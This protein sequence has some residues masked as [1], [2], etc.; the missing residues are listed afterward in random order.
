MR[1]IV[2]LLL[3]INVSAAYSQVGFRRNNRAAATPELSYSSP[4]ELEIAEIKVEGSEFLDANALISITGLKVGDVIKV[5]GD[6]IS[7]AI[8]KLWQQGIIGNVSIQIS[9]IEEGK[10]FLVI[11]LTERPRLTRFNFAGVNKSQESELNDKIKLIKGRVLTDAVLKNTEINVKKYFVDKGFLNTE[12]K[13]TQAKDTLISNG[14]QL[15]IKVNKNAKVKINK[16]VF[17]GN[18][19]VKDATLKRKMKNTHEHAR[20]NIIEDMLKHVVYSSP[21]QWLYSLSHRDT[22]PFKAAK[23]YINDHVKLNVFNTS[24]LIKAD[25]EEDK[26]SLITY[27]NA[28][29]FRDA[30]IVSDTFYRHDNRTIDIKLTINEGRKYYFRDIIWSGNYVYTDAVLDRILDVKKGDVYDMEMINK[31]LNYNPQGADISSL[32]MD[33]GYLFFTINPVEVRVEGDSI[34]VEMRIFEGKQA[35]INKL[36]VKGN[37]RTSDHVILRE[38][39][40]LPG[41]KFNRSE[42]IR[43]QQQLSQLGYFDPEKIGLNPIPNFANSTVDIEFTL[44]ERSSDKIELSGGWGGFIGFIGTVGLVFNNF[45]TKNLFNLDKWRP[46]PVGDG[47]QFSIRAQAS[48]VQF[49]NYSVGFVEPWLGGK[50]PNSFSINFNHSIQRYLD[51]RTRDVNGALRVTGVSMGLGRRLEW[52]DNYFVQSNSINYQYY[53]LD[54]PVNSGSDFGFNNGEA[55]NINFNNT[56]SRNSV[57]N[58]LYP[59]GGSSLS[60]STTF[61]PPYSLFNKLDYNNASN[62]EKFKWVEYHK[63]M[64]DASYFVKVFDDLVLNARAHFGFLGGYSQEAGIGPFERFTLGGSGLAGQ[65]SGF[66][67]GADIIALRGYQDNSLRPIETVL[68]RET[69]ANGQTTISP[70]NISGGTI[71]NKFVMELRYPVSLNPSATIFLLTFAEAGNTWNNYAEFNP[72]ELKRSAG[73]GARIFMPAFGLIGLDWGYGFDRAPNGTGRSGPQFHFT[74]GQQIR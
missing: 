13:I 9:K 51:F 48:G 15:T 70:R 28:K 24:K 57:D 56:I 21:S 50:K 55:N 68:S 7:G 65:Q 41:Q 36:I 5:P 44:E 58:P 34:D 3:F 29:G 69:D 20:F 61:T 2:L 53:Y 73:V 23:E 14:V 49:Q 66:L 72:Y 10:V 52:P 64:F 47:Q 63:W 43:T 45:S 46:L 19:N 16:I 40:T 67:L 54:L 22:V 26:E 35:T 60:L 6:A 42:L 37:D 27:Y 1:Y 18:D 31:K 8:K 32:Y 39:R 59:R 38:I 74:I 62:A 4:R 17:E 33:D 25:F 71:F 11:Q 30:E 12:V